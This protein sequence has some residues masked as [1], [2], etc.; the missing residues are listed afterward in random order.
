MIGGHAGQFRM[1]FWQIMAI[2]H[3]ITLIFSQTA[4]DK[5]DFAGYFMYYAT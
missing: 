1:I 5:S 3:K 2:F 4:L